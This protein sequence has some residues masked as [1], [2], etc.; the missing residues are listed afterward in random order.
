MSARLRRPARSTVYR[1]LDT[2]RAMGAIEIVH[3]TPKHHCSLARRT[4]HQRHIV[5]ESCG[6]LA[7]VDGCAFHRVVEAI[8]SETGFDVERHT[9]EVFGRCAD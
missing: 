4:P 3:P 8:E 5:C 2:L 1:T 7:V 6:R 9:L